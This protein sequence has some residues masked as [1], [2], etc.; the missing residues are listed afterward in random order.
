MKKDF[1]THEKDSS[2]HIFDYRVA[3]RA[4]QVESIEKL[5]T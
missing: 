5:A 2:E 3:S 1:V 4:A